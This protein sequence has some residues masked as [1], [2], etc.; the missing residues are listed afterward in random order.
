MQTL[1]QVICKGRQKTSLRTTIAADKA[2][3]KFNLQCTLFKRTDRP[4]GWTKIHSLRP[5]ASGAINMQW[6]GETKVLTLRIITR[7]GNP[8]PIM[9]DFLDY[10]FHKKRAIVKAVN[11]YPVE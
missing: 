6:D 1:L 11:I 7:K 9:A 5:Q 3:T 10:L 8:G 4:E 2:L